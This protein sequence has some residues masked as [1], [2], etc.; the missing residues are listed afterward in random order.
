MG[1]FVEKPTN[2]KN[3][4]VSSRFNRMFQV[5]YMLALHGFLLFFLSNTQSKTDIIKLLEWFFLQLILLCSTLL[6]QKFEKVT[7]N[8]EF[9]WNYKKF[10]RNPKKLTRKTNTSKFYKLFNNIKWHYNRFL[11]TRKCR[12]NLLVFSQKRYFENPFWKKI[13]SY[14]FFICLTWFIPFT[15]RMVQK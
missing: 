8:F 6:F 3:F 7:V 11:D 9:L 4:H 14:Q 12:K 13:K 5:Y 1:K 15:C 10:C 2:N